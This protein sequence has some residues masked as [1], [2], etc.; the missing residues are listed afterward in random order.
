M[1]LCQVSETGNRWIPLIKY[2]DVLRK[3][4]CDRRLN[5][6]K[7][8]WW[9]RKKL[10]LKEGERTRHD[11][12]QKNSTVFF[13]QQTMNSAEYWN[14]N[15]FQK[16]IEKFPGREEQI[17]F[18]LRLFRNVLNFNFYLMNCSFLIY[19]YFFFVYN[20][21]QIIYHRFLYLVLRGREKL[22][23]FAISWHSWMSGTFLILSLTMFWVWP[24]ILNTEYTWMIFELCDDQLPGVLQS[25]IDLLSHSVSTSTT[26]SS[27]LWWLFTFCW[28]FASGTDTQINKREN[29]SHFW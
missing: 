18:L 6:L 3:C 22:Q 4:R 14:N 12:L 1:K 15:I 19:N 23:F 10:M 11:S 21:L 9:N 8:Y 24:F 7:G 28:H 5:L 2:V 20:S 16:S 13:Q 27:I 26:T 17:E 29:I 25:K